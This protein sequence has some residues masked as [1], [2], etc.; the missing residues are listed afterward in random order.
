M[1]DIK[2]MKK[3]L[4]KKD[5]GKFKENFSMA[6]KVDYPYLRER[7]E[8]WHNLL[9]SKQRPSNFGVISYIYGGAKRLLGA[10]YADSKHDY[11]VADKSINEKMNPH[12]ISGKMQDAIN[13]ANILAD[14]GK[15]S[16]AAFLLKDIYDQLEEIDS[17][18][19][20]KYNP[21]VEKFVRKNKRIGL[22]KK[23]FSF[24]F[25]LTF[26]GGA[27]LSFNLT[28][29]VIFYGNKSFSFL[30]VSL[31]LLGLILSLLFIKEIKK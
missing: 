3:E 16:K 14:L 25:L 15:N 6:S 30:G 29:N 24:S 12:D 20:K 23:L 4:D 17:K 1:M 31:F 2:K 19:V 28:G 27:L 26:F 22:F 8:V 11:L 5:Y 10:E 7:G 13:G 18:E 9:Q 21:Q